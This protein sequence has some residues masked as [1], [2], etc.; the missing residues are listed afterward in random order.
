LIVSFSITVSAS[1]K[2]TV[3]WSNENTVLG[4]SVITSILTLEP[5]LDGF[6]WNIGISRYVKSE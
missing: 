4:A 6:L 5:F 1:S 3:V 2:L